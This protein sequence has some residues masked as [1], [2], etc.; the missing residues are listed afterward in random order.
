MK[1]IPRSPLHAARAALCAAVSLLLMATICTLPSQAASPSADSGA[2]AQALLKRTDTNRGVCAVL[3]SDGDLPVAL[4]KASGLLVHVREPESG[5][6]DALRALADRA[7]FDIQRLAVERGS[8]DHLPYAENSVDIV[9]STRADASFLRALSA[10][11]VLRALR[12]EGTAIIGVARN[13]DSAKALG[14]WARAGNGERVTTWSDA[15]GAWVQFFKPVLKGAADWSHWEKSPDN[16]PVSDDAVIKA[17]YMTQFMATPYYIGMPALTTA[18]GG[19]TFLAIGHIAHHEREWASLG[20]V[21]ARNGYN[22]SVLWERKLPEGY[23]VHRSAFI[24]TKDTFYMIDGSPCLLLD[25]ITGREKGEIRIPGVDGDLKWIALKDGVLYAMS[26]PVDPPA[27]TVKGDR[28]IGGWSWADL[29]KL[30]YEKRIPHG[31]GDV[32]AAYR[33]DDKSVIWKHREETPIDSRGLAILEDRLFLYCPD[34]YLRS[35]STTS[36]SDKDTLK[37]I[38]EPGKGLISTPGWRTETMTVATPKALV[39]QGQT[40]MNVVGISTEN[41]KQLWQKKK[42]T[43]NPN[44]MFVDG[45]V[46]VGVGP[47]GR[48]VALDPVNGEQV[49]DL[50]F[51]KRACTRLTASTDSFFCRGEGMIRFDRESREVTV[52]GSARPACNDGVIPANGL[53]YLGPWSCDCNLSLIGAIARCSAG[54]FKFDHKARTAARLEKSPGAD[55][56]EPL[57]VTE[58][59]WPTYRGNN[60]RSGST[61]V[62]V[63]GVTKQW[64]YKPERTTV[65]TEAT[66]AGGLIFFGGED[67]RARAVDAE[68]GESRWTFPTAG[69]VKYPPTIAEGRAYFGSGDGH[70]Y[71][72]EA[73]TGRLLWRFRAAPVERNLM[74]Y[75]A[76]SSTWPV[77]TG[78]LVHDGMAYFAAGIVDHDGTYVYALDA[79]TGDIRWQNNSSGH[80][81]AAQRKGVSAQ[82]NLTV[83]GNA[84]L[85]AGG[86]V[87][88]P[89]GF[90]LKTGECLEKARDNN[91][92]QANGGK[93]VGVFGGGYVVAGGRILYSSPLNVETKGSFAM[94]SGDRR[95]QT[96]NFGGIPP[97]WND[98]TVVVIHFK[99]GNITAFDTPKLSDAVTRGIQQ[100]TDRGGGFQNNLV[101]VMT[102]RKEERWQS[103]VSNANKF[104]AVSLALTP[105]AVLTVA[106]YQDLSRARPQWFLLA[107][108]PEDGHTLFQQEL[109]GDPLPDGLLVDRDGR[110]VISMVDGGLVSF[111]SAGK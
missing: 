89:A 79:K 6:V 75:G 4:A 57:P 83:R 11:E 110:I 35:L 76:M 26:G 90:D 33:L 63:G 88:S 56:V 25:P 43:S 95:S 38:E 5:G 49:E 20:R 37:L 48:N 44:A 68:K 74:V 111:A 12:P 3:G 102:V 101:S 70:V 10:G 78:V 13:G 24:A 72:L 23:L 7:G 80:L 82:G 107:L 103:R 15:H 92:P 32:I 53:I 59:D 77:N 30:Y 67:G 98:Q 40:H 28:A 27:E 99:Y 41:G 65:P 91:Q 105:N 22:G 84:L 62:R 42:I 1:L 54:G 47:G 18:A 60:H 31:Y 21:M 9:V 14:D 19:R 58:R 73:A 16:N 34:K 36:G 2:L 87:I 96:L 50:G 46:I 64:H 81:N 69:I 8:L 51:T 55:D 52:D 45:K 86:N 97:V 66:A 17:P 108:A 29:S 93:F 85:L 100:Q 94:W 61:P 71:C 109:P 106:R 104:E 39:N